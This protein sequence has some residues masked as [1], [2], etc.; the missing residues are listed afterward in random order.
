MT[1]GR[2]IGLVIL[3]GAVIGLALGR[4]QL[5]TIVGRLTGKEAQPTERQWDFDQDE[6]RG[7][8]DRVLDEQRQ[9][10]SQLEGPQRERA[11]A[12]LEYYER[13]RA[14]VG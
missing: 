4:R 8:M 11:Q 12:F 1:R 10:V 7:L 14:A 9:R 13:R 5:G 3:A 2:L 6:L